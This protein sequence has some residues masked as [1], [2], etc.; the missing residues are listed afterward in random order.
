MRP[1]ARLAFVVER[2]VAVAAAVRGVGHGLGMAQEKEAVHGLDPGA[3]R[4]RNEIFK[5]AL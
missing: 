1:G 4:A 3:P 5:R 2:S